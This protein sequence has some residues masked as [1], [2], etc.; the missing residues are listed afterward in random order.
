MDALIISDL[1]GEKLRGDL[2]GI[3]CNNAM[4]LISSTFPLQRFLRQRH[5]LIT[6]LWWLDFQV[7]GF[8]SKLPLA[9][10]I[11]LSNKVVSIAAL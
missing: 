7:G 4:S 8:V 3:G 9:Y 5:F 10:I 1:S 2:R 6:F 11:P